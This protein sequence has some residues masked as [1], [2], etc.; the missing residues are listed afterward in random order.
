MAVANV[1]FENLRAEMARNNIAIKDMAEA[2]NITRDTMGNKLSRKTPI[3]L[4][5]AFN[6]T[7]K[8]FPGCDIWE[9]FKELADEIKSKSAQA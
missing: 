5:E 3:N 1:A 8:C 4:N 7:I 2:A 9:L 6:I